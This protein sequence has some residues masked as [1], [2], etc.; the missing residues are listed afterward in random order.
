MIPQ[1][2]PC[3]IPRIYD[4]A[5]IHGKRDC[6]DMIKLSILSKGK[7]PELSRWV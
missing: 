3:F 7:Y 5:T 1:K 2:Y 4:Y 6:I